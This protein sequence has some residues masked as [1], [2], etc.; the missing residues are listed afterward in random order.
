MTGRRLTI[1]AVVVAG[2]SLAACGST[3]HP[4]ATPQH[5]KAT[6]AAT[7]TT[8]ARTTASG[9]TVLRRAVVAAVEAD[10][11]TSVTALW[12]NTVPAKP[13]A[14]AGPALTNLRK[15]VAGR[16]KR[17][18]RIRMLKDRFR[19]I[20]A[21]LD[22]SYAAAT[23]VV[24]DVERVQPSHVSGK[25]LGKSVSQTEHVNLDLH[26]VGDSNQFVVWRAE[27]LK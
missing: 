25:P 9:T 23:A 8:T 1:A 27:Y 22:P 19:V 21:T 12:T 15:A 2:L 16:R 13:V 4:K 17:R 3:Q 6:R 14:T 20:S 26:R 24:I 18:I 11:K 10:H 7:S 5:P